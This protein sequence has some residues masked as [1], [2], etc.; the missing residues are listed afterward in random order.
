MNGYTI[1]KERLLASVAGLAGNEV[2]IVGDVMVDEYLMGDAERISP[3]APVPVV[4]V[5]EDRHLVGGAGNVA[6][7]VRTLGGVPRLISVCGTGTRAA[8]LRRVLDNEGIEPQ[9]VEIPGRPTTIKTRVIAR[10]QQM[11]RID[12]EDAS[13]V[14]GVHLDRLLAL[15]Q[16]ALADTR[17]VVVSDYGKGI[18]TASFMKRLSAMCAASS[19]RPLIL[20]D[21]KTPNFH[22]YK[23]VHMLTPN[24]KETSEGA[25]LPAGNREQ[26]RAAAAAIFRKLDCE[27]LLTTLGPQ[28]MALFMTPDDAWHVPTVAQKVY[29]VTGAGDTVIATVG[30]C[31][32]SGLPLLES[33]ILANYAA[34]IVVGQVGAATASPDE[35]RHAIATLDV[36]QVNRWQ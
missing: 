30:L 14:G 33:C 4:H 19:T 5:T 34:G 17:V 24:T 10:Q 15:V 2:L 23:G 8:L 21:P 29:D 22:L 31:L 13:P 12:R 16:D 28:G 1:D 3:E 7:N 27:H 26:I 20:V 32:A 6:R 25:G 9:L 11:L 18:V 36:P 35:L